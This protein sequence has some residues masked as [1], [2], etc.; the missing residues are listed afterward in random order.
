[1]TERLA[2]CSCCDA[3]AAQMIILK[4]LIYL[5]IPSTIV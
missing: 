3:C 5:A 2:N 4:R 1:M